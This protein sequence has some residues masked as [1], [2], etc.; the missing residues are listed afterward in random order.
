MLFIIPDSTVKLATSTV[1]KE[2]ISQKRSISDTI[3]EIRF[4][5]ILKK[6]FEKNK[7][8]KSLLKFQTFILN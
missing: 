4:L 3:F 2:I 1:Y 5:A 8:L 6:A 7:G